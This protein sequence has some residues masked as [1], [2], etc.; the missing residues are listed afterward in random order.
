MPLGV[1]QE[2]PSARLHASVEAS[3]HSRVEPLAQLHAPALVRLRARAEPLA[4]TRELL[5]ERPHAL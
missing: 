2:L 4:R 5:S 3:A 1:E